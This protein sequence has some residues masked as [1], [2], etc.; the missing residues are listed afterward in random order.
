MELTKYQQLFR[1]F[2]DEAKFIDK[3]IQKLKLD[4]NNKILDIGTGMGAMS[5]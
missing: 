1:E 4:R 3:N 5:I 2:V